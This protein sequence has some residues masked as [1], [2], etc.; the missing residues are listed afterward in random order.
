MQSYLSE[1]KQSV[2]INGSV[3]DPCS[4]QLG[5]PRG[6]IL[7]PLLLNIYINSLPNATKDAKMIFYADDAVLL[8]AASTAAELKEYL[9]TGFTQ[10]C[11]WHC[12]NKLTLNVKKTKLMLTGS[13]NTLS[14]FENFEFKSDGVVIDCVKSFTYL[15]VT[16]DENWGWKPHIRNLGHCISV[17][18][19]ISHMLDQK[20]R[21]AYC[22]ILITL[23][24]SGVISLA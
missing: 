19:R 18:N 16:T 2:V 6:S 24:L 1:R 11:T 17:F 20:I 22:H 10:I 7:G 15:E 14:A 5:V 8:C 23:I 3:S 12:E 21:L 4:I 9:D 13:K